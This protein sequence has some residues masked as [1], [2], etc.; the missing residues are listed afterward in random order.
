VTCA[1]R[2]ET[3]ETRQLLAVA[4]LSGPIFEPLGLTPFPVGSPG[5][6]GY[7]PTQIRHAYGF[8]SL[9]F[10]GGGVTADGSGQAIAILVAYDDPNIVGDLNAFRQTFNIPGG[11]NFTKDDLNAGNPSPLPPT[12]PSRMKWAAEAAL[13]V[14]WV[15]ALAPGASIVLV[16]AKSDSTKD[17][18]VDGVDFASRVANVVVLSFGTD[19]YPG[20]T[21]YDAEFNNPRSGVTF[22]AASGDSGAPPQYPASS[23]YVLGAGGTTLNIDQSGNY[24]SETG[25]SGSGGGPSQFETQPPFQNPLYPG[26]MR[27]VPDVAFDADPAT[28]V[29][30]YDTFNNSPAAPWTKMAGTSFAAPAWGAVV[31]L[32]NQGRLL[33]QLNSLSGGDTLAK[34]YGLSPDNFHDITTG[35]NGY[36]AGP[37]YDLVTGRGSPKVDALVPNLSGANGV[38]SGYVYNDLNA[39]GSSDG[40]TDPGIDGLTVNLY[41]DTNGNGTF[42]SGDT[43][44]ATTTTAQGAGDGSYSFTSLAPG[45]YFVQEA[46][47]TGWTITHPS[48]P[49][50]YTLTIHSNQVDSGIDF[51]DFQKIGISGIAFNDLTGNGTMMSGSD[52]GVNT[53]QVNLYEDE[54]NTGTLNP[55]GDVLVG[56]TYTGTNNGQDGYFSFD[57]VGPG[58]YFVQEILPVGATLTT[59]T[60]TGYYTVLP[61]SGQDVGNQNFGNFANATLGGQV[62]NDLN[63]DGTDNSGTDPGLNSVHVNLYRDVN[64][65]GVFASSDTLL[66]TTTTST[67]G[68]QQG[69]FTFGNVG[70]GTYFVQEVT[71][72]GSVLTTP[73]STYTVTTSSGLVSDQLDFGN[74]AMFGVSGREFNDRNGDGSDN[75]GADPGQ[76]G[77]TI[78]LFRDATGTGSF[79]PSSDTLVATQ[80]SATI[81]TNAGAYNFPNLGPGTYF[82]HTLV[83][84][85]A[86]LTT[87]S[88]YTVVGQSGLAVS[89]RNF[90]MFQNVAIS[91]RAF[92][93]LNGSG[94]DNNADPGAN[95]YTIQ[96]YR[97]VN[98]SGH[99]DPANDLLVGTAVTST[100]SGGDGQYVFSGLGPGTYFVQ[101]TPRPGHIETAPGAPGYYTIT[102]QSGIN[103]GGKDFGNLPDVE[104]SYVYTLY[105]TLLQRPPDP[106]GLTYFGGLLD[107]GASRPLVSQIL[108]S[109][110]EFQSLEIQGLY[111]QYLGRPADLGGL[112]FYL[113]VLSHPAN[114]LPGET[115]LEAV[116]ASLL[117]SQEFFV[118]HPPTISGFPNDGY[119]HALYQTTL[120]RDIDSGALTYWRGLLKNGWSRADV[121]RAVVMSQ[122]ADQAVVQ[123]DYLTYLGRAADPGGL[124]Y[125]AGQLAQGW[126]ET[127]VIAA[128]V[129]SD[130][131]FKQI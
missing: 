62:F 113:Q 49:G 107:A 131:Y 87:T 33:S 97:D 34:I 63:G 125:F 16:E 103:V 80:T 27:G 18:L 79:D 23:P 56:T 84:L 112:N 53:I 130:E 52:P 100:Q 96:L 22:V 31:A 19:E 65:T 50:V 6:T 4:S 32:A 114:L 40:G 44:I 10:Q 77:I 60:P 92:V 116:K 30:V 24:I 17:L 66:A 88:T 43:L 106:S 11:L 64:G 120:N 61:T 126:H 89:G 104:Y 41:Q 118:N 28:G 57:G 12:D 78:Q 21:S 29:A 45:T 46:V 20:E 129:S 122:E 117:G 48:S 71:P 55:S 119:L 93:D 81:G 7:T 58:H 67:T 105:N 69:R 72:A 73:N 5:P 35:F 54:A 36:Q 74:F 121:A 83:P 115:P 90:G 47:P 94:I 82:V 128:F 51:G 8:D 99:L 1:L 127:D 70:P 25:W 108:E 95:G 26:P 76:N 109:S 13:D 86:T 123:V 68:G 39:D 3:L 37:G 111:H 91:G 2:V 85:E 42:G 59:P 9:Q 102:P 110:T 15:N 75:G 98:N 38:I 101:E 14:E 124:S